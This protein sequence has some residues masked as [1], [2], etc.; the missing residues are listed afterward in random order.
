MTADSFVKV[1]LEQPGSINKLRSDIIKR[2]EME[3]RRKRPREQ[4]GKVRGH[5]LGQRQ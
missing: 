1:L 2:K 3:N 5:S 4:E